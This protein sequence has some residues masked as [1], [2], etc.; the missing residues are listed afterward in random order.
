MMHL[1]VVGAV[2]G[3]A[4]TVISRQGPFTQRVPGR[5]RK[6][7]VVGRQPHAAAALSAATVECDIDMKGAAAGAKGS[8]CLMSPPALEDALDV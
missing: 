4:P 7:D 3:T 8:Y 1:E 6:I 2:A 5:T